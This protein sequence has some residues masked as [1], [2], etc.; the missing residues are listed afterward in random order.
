M[1]K[2][3]KCHS[4]D[5]SQYPICEGDFQTV[6]YSKHL[7]DELQLEKRNGCVELTT[8]TLLIEYQ[9]SFRDW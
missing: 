5:I 7:N 9:I 4:Y 2:F 8:A 3:K 6:P 1:Q